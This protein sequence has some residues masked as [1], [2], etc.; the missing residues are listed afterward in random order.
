MLFLSQIIGRPILDRQSEPIAT[1][2]DLIVH[3]GEEIYPPAVGLMARTGS[4]D[5]F[6]PWAQVADLSDKGASLSSF[7]VNLQP[8]ARRDGEI[9]LIKDVLDKQLVD[10]NGKRVVRVND[11]Q[12]A[13]VET[14][15]RVVGVDVSPQAIIRRLGPSSWFGKMAS[16]EIIDW[17][18]IE[19]L[20]SHAPSV[21]LKMSHERLSKLHPVDIA[22]I[23]DSLSYHQGAEI[24]GSLDPAT[25]ADTIEE[26]S[27]ERQVD[28]VEGMEEE[29]AADILE[30]MAPDEAADILAEL[31]E[32]KAGDLLDLMDQ[33]EAEDVRE[34]M[35]YEENTAGGI[36]TTDFAAIASSSTVAETIEHIRRLEEKP[37][38]L[39]Y[40]YVVE[41]ETDGRLV[42]AVSLRDLI[43][44]EPTEQITD[45][46]ERHLIVADSGD[47]GR[48]VARK[49]A[50]YNLQALPIVDEKR[51][52]LG[53]VTLDDAMEIVLP[54]PWR[55]RLPRIF[56]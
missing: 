38:F 48:D 47:S 54:E 8:F 19:Y 13:R 43:M 27:P 11:L 18:N 4:R 6:V 56:R 39:F 36:M 3:L 2:K 10:V 33:E 34:L 16:R 50:E 44:A 21:R 25:A 52:I 14:V 53:V 28:I 32:E 55:R 46:M 24:V 40:I 15:V 7:Q 51:E 35:E 42:G 41:S 23:I 26:M 17:A 20:V 31:S 45:I 37:D 12:L 29:K 30:E 5:F 9:L 49:I 1:I 22:R